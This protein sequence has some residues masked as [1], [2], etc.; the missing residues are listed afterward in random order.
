MASRDLLII[1]GDLLLKL[2]TLHLNVFLRHVIARDHLR[3]IRNILLLSLC[4][5]LVNVVVDVIGI[6]EL[7]LSDIRQLLVVL[8][9]LK[10]L[11][12]LTRPK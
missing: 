11:S 1:L 3:Y 7:L 5:V 2:F 12:E 4:L 8:E 10:F 6:Y 9:S